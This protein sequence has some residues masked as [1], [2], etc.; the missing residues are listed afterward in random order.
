MILFIDIGT[1]GT[2][3]SWYWDFGD[4][5][6]SKHAMNATHT[7]NNP[8]VYDVTLTVINEAGSDIETI[9]GYIVVS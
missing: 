5:I 1:G 8:G 2:P 7:F 9:S 3:T 4:G 6:N